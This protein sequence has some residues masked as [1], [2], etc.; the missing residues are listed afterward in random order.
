MFSF[1]SLPNECAPITHYQGVFALYLIVSLVLGVSRTYG[2]WQVQKIVDGNLLLR[3]Y[4][5]QPFNADT[6]ASTLTAD[7][8]STRDRWHA[9]GGDGVVHTWDMRTRR[10]LRRDIDEGSLA[11]TALAV[12]PSGRLFATGADSGVVNVY[13]RD[14]GVQRAIVAAVYTS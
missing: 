7:A 11:A 13:R 9:A 2:P 6:K 3:I 5:L 14:S 1:K 8:I 4:K 12:A 10:C